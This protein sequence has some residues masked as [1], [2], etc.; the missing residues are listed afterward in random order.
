[1]HWRTYS[2][3]GAMACCLSATTVAAPSG[4]HRATAGSARTKGGKV[5][6]VQKAIERWR[7]GRVVAVETDFVDPAGQVIARRSVHFGDSPLV[8]TETY[9]DLRSGYR[10]ESRALSGGAVE[11]KVLKAK[12]ED[13]DRKVLRCKYQSVNA[14]G[15]VE[16]IRAHW[17]KLSAG[18]RVDISLIVPQRQDWY[19]FRLRKT[20]TGRRIGKPTTTFVLEPA[21]G[22]LRA[23]AGQLYFEFDD[24]SGGLARYRGQ[25]DVHDDDGDPLQIDIAWLGAMPGA[26][27]VAAPP[28]DPGVGAAAAPRAP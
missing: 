5:A 18:D 28:A 14:A 1:M 15:V 9:E 6:Y 19:H 4:A 13:T 23:I 10:T 2:I 12:G 24:E 25:V 20:A 3:V 8:P 7:D 26:R 21:N 17:A 11:I 16:A 22:L 27:P